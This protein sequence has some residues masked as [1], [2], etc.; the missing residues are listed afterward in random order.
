MTGRICGTGSY[1]PARIVENDELANLV[2]TND[3]WIR[4]RTGIARRHLAE[5]ETTSYMAAEAA[6]R[7]LAQS[8]I[9]AEDVDLI[10]VATSTP[11][12][13]FPCTACEVQR[14]IH[15][16]HAAGFDLNAACSGFLFAL[17][18]AQAYI[19]AGIYRT[20]LVIGVDSM[21]HM[22]DWSDRSTCI[23][24]GD[25][26]GAVVLRESKGGLFVQAAH[27]DGAKGD[28]LTGCSRHRKNWDHP[29]EAKAAYIQM[30]GQSVFKFA[31]RRVPE[32]VEELLEKARIQK[33]E[34]SYFFLHQA[35]RRIIEAAAKRTGVDIS[36]FPMNLQEYGNTSAASIPILLDEWNRKGL[37]QKRRQTDTCR[38]WS[39][40]FLGG[41]SVGM[42]K[43]RKKIMLEKI[44]EITA[45]SLGADAGT[46]TEETSFKED[47]GADSLDLFE[48]VMAF[49]EAFEV[50]IPSEDLEQ[51]QTVGDVVKYL[52]AHK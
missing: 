5:N 6:K 24:F 7:A 9:P 20:V 48:M 27:S 23:L 40:T 1:V 8:D 30:D 36:R 41:K 2:D 35:N 43:E 37:L 10:L 16:E 11:E 4:E 42:V 32:I 39:R 28:V 18:T 25:G 14:E 12:N 38:I 21:S 13:V 33:E 31:V 47:L 46:I 29:D 15:A 44:K 19:Q 49:E 45:E 51:I 50:E 34:I 22:V 17:Q 3:A 52:E 26:A